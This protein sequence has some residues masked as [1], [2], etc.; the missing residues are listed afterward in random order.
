MSPENPGHE[1]SVNGF[2]RFHHKAASERVPGALEI[3][4]GANAPYNGRIIWWALSTNY[5]RQK[6]I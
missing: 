6:P 4:I 2:L 5:P 3:I 1:K